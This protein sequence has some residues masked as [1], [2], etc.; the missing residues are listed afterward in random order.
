MK[1]TRYISSY[2]FIIND[3][4]IAEHLL[5]PISSGGEGKGKF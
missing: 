5:E 4:K 2:G 1:N 3:E